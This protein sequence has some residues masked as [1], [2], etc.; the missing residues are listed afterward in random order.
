MQIHNRKGQA[1]DRC[2]NTCALRMLWSLESCLHWA[3]HLGH[4]HA[5]HSGCIF[6]SL[7]GPTRLTS[8]IG[9]GVAGGR[10]GAALVNGKTLF[11]ESISTACAL[12]WSNKPEGMTFLLRTSNRSFNTNTTL[13]DDSVIYLPKFGNLA[14]T[15]LK[16]P[17]LASAVNPSNSMVWYRCEFCIAGIMSMP[18]SNWCLRSTNVSR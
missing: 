12:I 16:L 4:A 15:L 17:S 11:Y 5:S 7:T 2:I 1:W 18:V 14:C 9:E 3:W 10:V 8:V 13:I 6:R